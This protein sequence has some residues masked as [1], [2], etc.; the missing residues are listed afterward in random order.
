M[1]W[2]L[3]PANG[4]IVWSTMV[5]PGSTLGGIQ[6]G[7]ATDG[8]RIYVAITNGGKKP[9]PL[10]N[11]QTVTSGAWSALDVH[12]GRILW[13]TPD[14]DQ[15]FDMGSVSVANGVLY[16]P[17]FSGRMLALNALTGGILWSFQ[18]GGSVLDGPSIVDGVV[19]WGS[20]YRN[21]KPGIGNNKV[22]AFSTRERAGLPPTDFTITNYQ[23]VRSQPAAGN[24]SSKTY[25]AVLLNPN[26]AF[27]SVTAT[28]TSLDPFSIRVAPGQGT[29][30]FA[31]VPAQ[32][33]VT[34]S[35]TFTI[36]LDPT[37]PLDPSK[38]QWTFQ[39]TPAPPVANPGPNQTVK[40]GSN[41][42]LDGSGST[43]PSGNG[44]LTYSWRF[45]SRPAGT[46]T[47]LTFV[48]S[49]MPTFVADVAGTYVISLTA[50][51]GAASS[52]ASVTIIASADAH[53]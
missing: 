7:T 45:I 44:A 35:N 3:N 8:E 33:Q 25:R 10:I 21:I 31:P 52:S 32:S 18:S 19:Y 9:Y 30:A 29:L 13:Q 6:W 51:N 12:S 53:Q 28:L 48:T 39:T 37:V 17:S 42:R 40:V 38:L 20:G 23:L 46:T 22:F 47:V 50:S 26:M 27:A 2:A 41:V 11:G 34:S 49:V 15:A 1:Y 36:I 4:D 43:N 16:A 14:P 5:G 24:L